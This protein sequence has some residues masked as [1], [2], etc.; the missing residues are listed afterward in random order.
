MVEL[1]STTLSIRQKLYL[2]LLSSLITTLVVFIFLFIWDG[3]DWGFIEG[4]L[5]LNI[6][7]LYGLGL[8][9]SYLFYGREFNKAENK[10]LKIEKGKTTISD[11]LGTRIYEN[12]QVI[13]VRIDRQFY[14]F[15]KHER[16][17]ISFK[18]FG[19]KKRTHETFVL[20]QGKHENLKENIIQALQA[21]PEDQSGF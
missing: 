2:I 15:I 4:D 14:A 17:T 5:W 3:A 21:L 9:F 11:T 6:L 19:I 18:T 10:H 20:K 13:N 16:L 8:V 7:F 12:N 1:T